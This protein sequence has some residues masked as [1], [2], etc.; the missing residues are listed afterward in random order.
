M[1]SMNVLLFN[2]T[3]LLF[4]RACRIGKSIIAA[5]CTPTHAFLIA[6]Y[7]S[8]CFAYKRDKTRNAVTTHGACCNTI[9]PY[10]SSL[11]NGQNSSMYSYNKLL[12]GEQNNIPDLGEGFPT[13]PCCRSIKT[14][15]LNPVAFFCSQLFCSNLTNML[16]F[17]A[18][19]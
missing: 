15:S 1:Q 5:I 14:T 2:S 4:I 13:I 9:E 18:L 12:S 6:Y 10:G 11:T 17:S 7:A 3:T 8:V 19:G 16:N